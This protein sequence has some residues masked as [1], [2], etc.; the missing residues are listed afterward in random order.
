[1]ALS[2]LDDKSRVPGEEDL[3]AVLGRSKGAW[4]ELVEFVRGKCEPFAKEWNYSRVKYGWSLRLKHKKRNILYLIPRN[5]QFL[6]GLV[7]GEKAMKRVPSLE[8]PDAVLEII[9]AAPKYAEGTG[10]RLP[11][12]AKRDIAAVK[13]L[14]AVKLDY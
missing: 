10:F 13:R 4:D 3:V 8:L 5:R 6:I 11:V 14:L 7:L 12:K 9:E 2:S 1:M